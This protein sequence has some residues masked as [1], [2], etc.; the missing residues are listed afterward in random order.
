MGYTFDLDHDFRRRHDSEV[1]Y[2]WMARVVRGRATVWRTEGD[3]RLDDGTIVPWRNSEWTW[4]TAEYDPSD[5]NLK[6]GG[7]HFRWPGWNASDYHLIRV[8]FEDLKEARHFALEY[9]GEPQP[10]FDGQQ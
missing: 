6:P 5:A 1:F 2:A 10:C 3:D 7:H 8:Y 4:V 9:G